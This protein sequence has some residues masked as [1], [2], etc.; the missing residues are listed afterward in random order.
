MLMMSSISVPRARWRFDR[1]RTRNQV[2]AAAGAGLFAGPLQFTVSYFLA[3][4][5]LRLTAVLKSPIGFLLFGPATRCI[6]SI[7]FNASD[8]AKF[9]SFLENPA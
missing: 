7:R 4:W 2:G 6:G 5:L 1:D 3:S 8:P 9:P